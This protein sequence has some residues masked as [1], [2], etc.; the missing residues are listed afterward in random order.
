[1]V[2]DFFFPANLSKI[3]CEAERTNLQ[4]ISWGLG[5]FSHTRL[6]S[7]LLSV[8]QGAGHTSLQWFGFGEIGKH[9]LESNPIN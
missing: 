6:S 2:G 1:M 3:K 9:Y 5:P 8:G 7:L 4:D